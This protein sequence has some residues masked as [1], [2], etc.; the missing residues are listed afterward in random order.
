MWSEDPTVSVRSIGRR[1]TTGSGSHP[2]A[3][4]SREASAGVPHRAPGVPGEGEHHRSK[5]LAG[6]EGC[7][8][9]CPDE[10]VRE[11]RHTDRGHRRG[12]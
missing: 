5:S 10:G 11:E 12:G 9:N 8:N 6:V 7:R 2:T 1:N 4:A 3:H